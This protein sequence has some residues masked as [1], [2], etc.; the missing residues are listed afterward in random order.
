MQF[1][2]SI[3]LICLFPYE[4]LWSN[5]CDIFRLPAGAQWR[6]VRDCSST[7]V[8]SAPQGGNHRYGCSQQWGHCVRDRKG[9]RVPAG[10]LS[11]QETGIQV[12]GIRR[13]GSVVMLSQW[14]RFCSV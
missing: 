8:R 12:S 13:L 7:G 3:C 11:V 1:H 14:S 10:R 6:E 9:R 5:H 2:Q 4:N